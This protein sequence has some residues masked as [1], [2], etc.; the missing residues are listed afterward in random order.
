MK[1]MNNGPGFCTDDVGRNSC[2]F[3]GIDDELVIAAS[4]DDNLNIWSLPDSKGQDCQ[5][6][7]PLRVLTT[8]RHDEGFINCIRYSSNSSTI[9]S[10]HGDGVI[11][12]WTSDPQG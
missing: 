8:G 5:V 1:L 3:A 12:L 10:S 4:D 2:C 9:I 7:Q 6:N 11:Q